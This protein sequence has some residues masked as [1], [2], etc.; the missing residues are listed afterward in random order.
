MRSP[1][2]HLALAL[3]A[4]TRIAH[5]DTSVGGTLTANTTWTA[6][7]SP[8]LVNPSVTVGAGA[9]LTIEPG[10]TVKFAAAS[11][12]DVS[13]TLA[14]LGTSESPI[15]FTS[16]AAPP[17]PGSWQA[18]RFLPGS[19]GHIAHAAI[20]FG[21]AGYNSTV[22]VEGGAPLLE[23]V[24]VSGSSANGIRVQGATTT[25]T[26]RDAVVSGNGE[27][28][29]NLLSGGGVDVSNT[30]FINNT[31]Y[32]VGA[33][34]GT[35]LLGMTN[36]SV[37]GNGGGAKDGIG[38]RGGTIN[39]TASWLPGLDWLLIGGV[40]VGTGG[41]L[42][43]APGTRVKAGAGVRLDVSGT[44]TALG[45]SANP[46]VFTT[47][48]A[49]PV[50]GSWQCLYF[51]PGSSAS[52]LA[53]AT[54]SYGG[55]G[56]S[57]SV[58]IDNSA[59][60]FER[61]TITNSSKAGVWIASSTAAVATFRNCV[62]VGNSVWGIRSNASSPRAD[63]RLCYWGDATGPSGAGPGGGQWVV[64]GVD[65]EPWLSA[66]PADPHLFAPLAHL[67]RT[68]NPSIGTVTSLEFDTTSAGSWSVAIRD[69][70]GALVRTLTGSPAPASAVWDGKDE[71]GILQPDATYRYELVSTAGTG[72]VAAARG[73]TVLDSSKQLTVTGVAATPAYLSPNG[74]GIQESSAVT[75]AISFEASW[76]VTVKDAGGG[77]VRSGSGSGSAVSYT[78]DGR[79]A[80]G[81]VAADGTYTVEVHATVG[82]ASAQAATD[83]TL[84]TT[85]P[86]VAI[87]S[88]GSGGLLSNV[89]QAGSAAPAIVGTASDAHLASWTLEWG[90]GPAPATWS[91][92]GTGTTGVL[93]GQ[94][95]VWP[96]L[97]QPNGSYSLRLRA[98]DL[99]GNGSA[100][101]QPVVIG[102]LSASQSALQFNPAAGATVT[103]TSIVPFP[104]SSA[105]RIQNE[106]GQVVRT[107]QS[108]Q[109]AAG[110]YSDVWD[111]RTDAGALVPDGPYFYLV[112][113][114]D[115]ASSMVWD[116]R[117]EYLDNYQSWN[118][119]L[120]LSP[121]DPF[122][123]QPLTFTYNFP[124]PGRVTIG[125]APTL[126]VWS[127]CELPQFCLAYNHYEASGP[128]TITWA[129][130][131]PT[132]A[133]RGD[134]LSVAVVIN[135]ILFS[136]NAVVAYGTRPAL[137]NVRVTPPHY[138]PTIGPQTVSFDL[139]TYQGQPAAVTVTFFNQTSRTVLR[140]LS[141]P[142][143]APGSI[144]LAWDGRADNGVLVAPGPYTV[145][146]TAT[147]GL[148]NQVSGQILTTIQY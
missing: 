54:I 8:Y 85:L 123:N 108:G 17:T 3:L 113:A 79:D 140:T 104:L 107:L 28:G 96:T 137:A 117:S 120:V 63:A 112:E 21:G 62:L 6:A 147:D 88:P 36:L 44:L 106:A 38:Y 83:A 33:E 71:G 5:A 81:A 116:L 45:T 7:A 98:T 95:G 102:N 84:D 128:H 97:Q 86:A 119:S 115:G 51:R 146:V 52:R 30:A 50:P 105:V 127:T 41:T 58:M 100:L 20:Q 19:A 2:V 1:A 23:H 110:T 57:G 55:S 138:G 132:G 49:S 24:T 118:D 56:Y 10:V 145:T 69:G 125:F 134:I 135:R 99:A 124:Q 133:Y 13:G 109:R 103:Y 75:A 29:L 142:S 77:V 136:K 39:G 48:A 11:R 60:E 53:H 46:I 34:P 92:L 90:A 66:L 32:A 76:T 9:T 126:V 43:I 143:Q 65:Y 18:I 31:S 72:E 16:S 67:N 111:G 130:V 15:T 22:R 74:D 148:G 78:W 101:V 129:G 40:F 141:V 91:S 73:L 26:L 47:S 12:L 94:L 80:A 87:T 64:A 70:A 42:D 4:L 144:S 93:G 27:H 121:F 122:D 139:A 82:T 68:F 35:R 59:V 14:A 114:A 131:D 37:T 25:L 89:H 61:V